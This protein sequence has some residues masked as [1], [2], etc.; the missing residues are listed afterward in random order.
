MF[1][2]FRM[3]VIKVHLTSLSCCFLYALFHQ[4]VQANARC[5]SL[6]F[7]APSDVQTGGES[8]I[9]RQRLALQTL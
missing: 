8:K 6:E 3:I 1:S 7:H 4:L 9:N 5:A 2:Y